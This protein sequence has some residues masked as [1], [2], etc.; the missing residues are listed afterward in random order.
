M[1]ISENMFLLL[2]KQNWEAAKLTNL[3]MRLD[4]CTQGFLGLKKKIQR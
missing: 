2:L 1:I 4:I 3:F